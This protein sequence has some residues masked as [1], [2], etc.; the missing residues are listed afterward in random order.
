MMQCISVMLLHDTQVERAGELGVTRHV[1]LSECEW[2]RPISTRCARENRHLQLSSLQADLQSAS[3]YHAIDCVSAL[4]GR[5]LVSTRSANGRL[6]PIGPYAFA[7]CYATIHVSDAYNWLRRCLCISNNSNTL[8]A[9]SNSRCRKTSLYLPFIT[10]ERRFIAE[11]GQT[12][13]LVSA[14]YSKRCRRNTV[15]LLVG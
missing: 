13:P 11:K 10:L 9:N 6:S 4:Y 15:G 12:R 8:L 2:C 14:A 1:M 5:R 3:Y 7:H